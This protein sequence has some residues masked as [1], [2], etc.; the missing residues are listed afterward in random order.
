MSRYI[1]MPSWVLR[2]A[3]LTPAQKII[4]SEILAAPR[5]ELTTKSKELGKQWG[6]TP[7]SVRLAFLYLRR[8]GVV[9]TYHIN[10]DRRRTYHTVNGDIVKKW[11][12]EEAAEDE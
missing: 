7:I 11:I 9:T 2:R 10:G 1:S 5:G 8:K 4:I 6:M 3:D 12:E